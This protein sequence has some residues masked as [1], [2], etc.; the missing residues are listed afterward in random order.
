MIGTGGSLSTPVGVVLDDCANTS[1]LIGPSKM[2]T[3]WGCDAIK[4]TAVE[5][6][7]RGALAAR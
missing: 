1:I 6:G 2:S 7:E 4:M 3:H 5:L